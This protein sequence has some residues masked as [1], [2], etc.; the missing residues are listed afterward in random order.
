MKVVAVLFTMCVAGLLVSLALLAAPEAGV[1]QRA[2]LAQ[3]RKH[4]KGF[5]NV[6]ASSSE[7]SL[8]T[9]ESFVTNDGSSYSVRDKKTNHEKKSF[10]FFSRFFLAQVQ[11][12]GRRVVL[13]GRFG[14][15]EQEFR[16][17]FPDDSEKFEKEFARF[18]KNHRIVFS[19]P[20]KTFDAKLAT[21]KN[22]YDDRQLN[23]V[24][25]D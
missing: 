22:I 4:H 2:L 5:F 9:S 20:R 12:D 18:L 1:T 3:N 11:S 10:F 17:R 14:E 6:K 23:S 16:E 7:T 19:P 8:E 21:G 24:D 15:I 25:I 13:E